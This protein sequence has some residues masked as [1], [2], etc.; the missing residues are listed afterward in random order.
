MVG[1]WA[2]VSVTRRHQNLFA[3]CWSR[4]FAEAEVSLDFPFEAHF[5]DVFVFQGTIQ[6]YVND[7][8]ETIFSAVQRGHSAP[9]AVK[10]LFD[11]LDNQAAYYQTEPEIVHAWKSNWY[12]FVFST[13]AKY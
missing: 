3:V 4:L 8:F 6:K 9:L 1:R 7:L 11:Y 10:H 13:K 5:S 12:V 2:G